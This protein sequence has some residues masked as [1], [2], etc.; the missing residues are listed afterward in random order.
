MVPA[1][2]PKLAIG[3]LAAGLVIFA[4]GMVARAPM[5]PSAVMSGVVDSVQIVPSGAAG[6]FGNRIPTKAVAVFLPKAPSARLFRLPPEAVALADSLHPA[7]TVQALLGWR[8]E[9]DT[10]TALRIMRNGVVLLDST[11]MLSRQRQERSRIGLIGGLFALVGMVML[12][13]RAPTRPA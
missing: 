13:R 2:S 1:Q 5:S 6:L 4:F 8:S 12:I 10:A 11:L 7:D 9:S 3:L